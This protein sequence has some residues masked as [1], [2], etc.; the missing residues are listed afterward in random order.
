MLGSENGNAHPKSRNGPQGKSQLASAN[1]P[2]GRKG[3]TLLRRRADRQV[4]PA[5]R[6][7]SVLLQD[8]GEAFRVIAH[9]SEPPTDVVSIRTMSQP[10]EH[11][12]VDRKGQKSNGAID[13]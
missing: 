8:F 11:L 1:Q 12:A 5:H 7:R 13:K 10:I 4:T 3:A 2:W 6:S 9:G